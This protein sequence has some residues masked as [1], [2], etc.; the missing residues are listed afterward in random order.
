MRTLDVFSGL[1]NA[2][3]VSTIRRSAARGTMADA[4]SLPPDPAFLEMETFGGI[5]SRLVAGIAALASSPART[6]ASWGRVRVSVN[7][8]RADSG[9]RPSYRVSVDAEPGR[10]VG[11]GDDSVAAFVS[12]IFARDARTVLLPEQVSDVFL[13]TATKDEKVCRTYDWLGSSFAHPVDVRDPRDSTPTPETP[14]TLESATPTPAPEDARG[15]LRRARRDSRPKSHVGALPSHA[16]TTVQFTWA[17]T[18]G[19][20][21]PAPAPRRARAVSDEVVDAIRRQVECLPEHARVDVAVAA[22]NEN[23]SEAAQNRRD[24][25]FA[26]TRDP[27]PAAAASARRPRELTTR[28]VATGAGFA[29]GWTATV[30][31]RF[32]RLDSDAADGLRRNGAVDDGFGL[33]R[34]F[35]VSNPRQRA[36]VYLFENGALLSADAALA[37]G[38]LDWICTSSAS[39]WD[40]CNVPRVSRR[41]VRER[42]DGDGVVS[43]AF[44]SEPP[45]GSSEAAEGGGGRGPGGRPEAFQKHA[46]RVA[47]LIVHL[48][49][50]EAFLRPEPRRSDESASRGVG[51]RTSADDEPRNGSRREEGNDEDDRSSFFFHPAALVAENFPRDRPGEAERA[52]A[53]LV[54]AALDA[55]IWRAKRLDAVTFASAS[56]RAAAAAAATA[57]DA[58]VA[59]LRRGERAGAPFAVAAARALGTV[60]GADWEAE[61]RDAMLATAF[62]DARYS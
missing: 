41:G 28:G 32:E 11:P 50:D 51:P 18:P 30:S 42:A 44:E 23:E 45:D 46:Y 2:R 4:T 13:A 10:G 48:T 58:A 29:R 22:A 59:T 26:S 34:G 40:A 19:V 57:A 53:R 25:S 5:V 33:S 9:R 27:S 15:L 20:P 38:A 35:L 60:V 31:V 8:S 17:P 14:E 43:L 62:E 55:A 37:R 49:R 24:A 56:E 21:A 54:R 52:R 16:F 47:E 12:R 6:S 7:L 61:Y 36:R 39:V 3:E 1:E